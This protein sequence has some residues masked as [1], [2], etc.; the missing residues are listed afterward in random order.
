MGNNKKWALFEEE[1]T[2]I[3]SVLDKGCEKKIKIYQINEHTNMYGGW[4]YLV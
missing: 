3:G 2:G 4:H 1:I